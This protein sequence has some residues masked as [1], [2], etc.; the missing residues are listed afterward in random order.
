MPPVV[1][2]TSASALDTSCG[3][4]SPR[5]PWWVCG[6]AVLA[7]LGTA[8]TVWWV[9]GGTPQPRA[10]NN[11][12]AAYLL[13]ARIFASG[14]WTA[15][16]RPLP[17]FFEQWNVLVAPR[18]AAKYPPV[19]SALLALGAWAGSM[20]WAVSAMWAVC[21][22]VLLG[23]VGWMT[24][25]R[26]PAPAAVTAA[27]ATWAGWMASPG[28]L[29]FRSSY[30]SQSTSS[31]LVLAGWAG[32]ALWHGARRRA[33]SAAGAGVVG[34]A[35]AT[36]FLTRPMTAL[37]TALPLVIIVFMQWHRSGRTPPPPTV[38]AMPV[39]LGSVL[40]VVFLGGLWSFETTGRVFESPL[41]RY[42][43]DYMPWDHV[44][45]GG[46]PAPTIPVPSWRYASDALYRGMHE[47]YTPAAVLP[48]VRARLGMTWGHLWG[49]TD[50]ASDGVAA[51]LFLLL[52]GIGLWRWRRWLW[53]PAAQCA[54]AFLLYGA[55][56][57]D[58]RWT[59]YYLE[60]M[61]LLVCVVILGFGEIAG[62]CARRLGRSPSSAMSITLAVVTAWLAV[63]GV[64]SVLVERRT[65][66]SERA[67][68][69]EV[70]SV[71]ASL[72][73]DSVIAFVRP[74]R[75]D[76]NP[77]LL[78]DNALELDRARVWAVHDL[79]AQNAALRAYARG[80]TA[81]LVDVGAHRVERLP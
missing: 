35:V 38:S 59:L 78:V 1:R 19:H 12:E 74:D 62:W 23:L 42:T 14:H 9:W 3:D 55:Y 41:T 72:P 65:A 37:A 29:H 27:A 43:R 36:L 33:W 58:A 13:Q 15:A 32:V 30:F 21:A 75:D 53:L 22:I 81:Y 54:A 7:A 44:G 50:T 77:G 16:G 80:R 10:L 66:M 57:S 63:R 56:A 67:S 64:P 76:Q 45:F 69:E 6:L 25:T 31:L 71:L 60:W 73:G 8:W 18:L 49:W 20:A 26:W 48:A 51:R 11:D 70:G 79:G 28:A 39:M 17:A 24:H 2:F 34:A 47:S 40:C 52:G 5:V 4:P 61:P 46:G 68:L